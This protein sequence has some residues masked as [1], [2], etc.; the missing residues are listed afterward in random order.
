VV[1]SATFLPGIV[2]GSW[3]SI[4]GQNLA[5]VSRTWRSDEFLGDD[6]SELPL[7]VDSVSVTI[8]GK[9]AAV[10]YV[11]PMQLNVQAP[12]DT[13]TGP[14]SVVVTHDGQSTPP[15]Q[16]AL[17]AAAPAFFTYA[18][19]SKLFAAAVDTNGVVMG[20]PSAVPGAKAA[21]PG[22]AISIFGTGFSPSTGGTLGVSVTALNPLPVVTIGGIA[23]TV[24][25]GGLTTPGLFQVN[26]VVPNL[27][28]G[29]YPVQVSWNG[30][31]ALTTPD[32]F[33]GSN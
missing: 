8:D 25:F 14:V 7:S 32:L 18:S 4:F 21:A 16:A 27:G 28:P 19:G 5:T 15:V 17:E 30:T 1:S 26:V 23:A 24:T 31:A 29:L 9:P 13:A 12:T 10:Y 22:E 20:D 2:G 6:F 33:V 3:V 11:S